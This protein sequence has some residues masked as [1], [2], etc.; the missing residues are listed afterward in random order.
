MGAC[1]S[2]HHDTVE[3]YVHTDGEADDAELNYVYTG[4]EGEQVGRFEAKP[5]APMNATSVEIDP[6]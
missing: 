5:V 4:G 2:Q 6:S 1:C 3:N